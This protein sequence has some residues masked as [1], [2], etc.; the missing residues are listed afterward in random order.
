MA[1]HN[2]LITPEEGSQILAQRLR[3]LGVVPDSPSSVRVKILLLTSSIT[4]NLDYLVKIRNQDN[5][6]I[7]QN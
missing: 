6:E 5:S 1:V 4:S 3:E 2:R 7:L